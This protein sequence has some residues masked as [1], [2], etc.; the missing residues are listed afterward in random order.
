MFHRELTE[1]R[2]AN[3]LTQSAAQVAA[4]GAEKTAKE[5]LR[6]L[7]LQQQLEAQQEKDRL[8]LQ[9]KKKL[10]TAFSGGFWLRPGKYSPLLM[11]L[12]IRS[13]SSTVAHSQLYLYSCL[14]LIFITKSIFLLVDHTNSGK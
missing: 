12:Y 6:E 10:S 11:C 8:V 3:A 2:K 4:L 14:F 13:I 9:V 1:L 5:E 7:L